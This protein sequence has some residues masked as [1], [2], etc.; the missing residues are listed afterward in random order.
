MA[1]QMRDLLSNIT[2]NEDAIV[3][4]LEKYHHG[5]YEL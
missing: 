5:F 3:Q 4:L 1:G 2:S